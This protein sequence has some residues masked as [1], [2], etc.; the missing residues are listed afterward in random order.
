M[1]SKGKKE[2]CELR[3]EILYSSFYDNLFKKLVLHKAIV[4]E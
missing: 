1:K 2:L 4:S 3:E